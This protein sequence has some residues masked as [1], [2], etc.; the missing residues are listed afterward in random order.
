MTTLHVGTSQDT[1][2]VLRQDSVRIVIQEE[3]IV[4]RNV[5]RGLPGPQGEPGLD[6]APGPQGETG[7]AGAQG[8]EG[9]VGPTGPEGP[10]GPTGPSGPEGPVGPPGPTGSQGPI[11]AQGPA[12][13]D[14]DTTAPYVTWSAS[15]SLEN[16]R[17]LAAGAGIGITNGGSGGNVA[18]VAYG[19]NI[20]EF[21]TSGSWVKPPGAL[22]VQV[23]LVGGGDGGGSGSRA[24]SGLRSGGAGGN[25]GQVLDLTTGPM[26]SAS[27]FGGTET[28]TIGA[29]GAGGAAKTSNGDGNPGGAGGTTMFGPYAVGS[30]YGTSEGGKTTRNAYT[31]LPTKVWAW[32]GVTN[33]AY[34]GGYIA[35]TAARGGGGWTYTT[36]DNQPN[37]RG[38]VGPRNPGGGGG[39]SGFDASN[40]AA[41][42]ASAGGRG[43]AMESGVPPASFIHDGYGGAAGTSA[44]RNGAAGISV[45][46][47]SGGG[48]GCAGD[49]AGT[50]PGGNG[51]AGG[52]PGGGGGGGGASTEPA[53]SGAGGSGANGY[54]MIIT[55]CGG[56]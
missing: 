54:A 39:G 31:P 47:G 8:P 4:L 15:N 9:P 32:D 37:Y 46:K 42:T 53:V 13:Q 44:S 45:F 34:I 56:S 2:H 43:Y 22:W 26:I 19:I 49:V 17:V 21:T 14:A 30:T 3:K 7:P 51:G 29:G 35:L 23:Y 11:G 18:I 6:G 10:V 36:N 12:G 40:N 38:A 52:F 33:G 1:L 27:L 5:E 28:V 25:G 55:Y 41:T 20:Q 16:A 24:A 48:G 50:V